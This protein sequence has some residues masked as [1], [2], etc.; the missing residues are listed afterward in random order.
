MF[1]VLE[2][3]TSYLVWLAGR[4]ASP[5]LHDNKKGEEG[6]TGTTGQQS[7]DFCSQFTI[8]PEFKHRSA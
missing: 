1:I 7:C 6:G 8:P 5:N 3:G 2:Y 4:G